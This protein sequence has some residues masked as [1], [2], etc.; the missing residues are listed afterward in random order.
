MPRPPADLA[1]L[2]APIDAGDLHLEQLEDQHRAALRAICPVDDPVWEVYPVRL[3]G[4]DFDAAFDGIVQDTQRYPFAIF[5]G[6]ALVGM[7][8]FLH[9]D[10][11]SRVL[12]IGGTYMTPAAR[13]T[14][15][16]SRIKP[17][18]IG[19]AIAAGFDR[20]EFRIDA[21]NARSLRA[22]EKLGAV[23]EGVLRK[24]RVTWT[25]HV[26][27]TVILSILASEWRA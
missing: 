11:P 16:N 21:R 22:V 17:L 13:G 23:K 10:R 26:R 8:G 12:E 4:E 14:G 9:L 24:Q 2:I 6:G 1:A 27:D 25:G 18:L 3:A 15:L 20:L 5:T 19:R 7:S